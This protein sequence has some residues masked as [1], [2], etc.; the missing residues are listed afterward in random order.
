MK[1]IVP[2]T[3]DLGLEEGIVQSLCPKTMGCIKARRERLCLGIDT[4]YTP[5]RQVCLPTALSSFERLS[6]LFY[7]VF[8][9]T[10]DQDVD[11]KWEHSNAEDN[12]IHAMP[13]CPDL[14]LIDQSQAVQARSK[15][16]QLGA[17]AVELEGVI[18]RK[19]SFASAFLR[20]AEY[21]IKSVS[22]AQSQSRD[23]P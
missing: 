14:G 9:N 19:A 17:N 10:R 1:D 2:V 13:I 7:R 16:S 4:L 15:R 18:F 23:I 6:C 22:A 5:A 12:H 11:T 20:A 3:L 8:V 21:Y